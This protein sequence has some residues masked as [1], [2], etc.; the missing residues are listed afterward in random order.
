MPMIKAYQSNF[1][2][3]II[4]SRTKNSGLLRQRHIQGIQPIIRK[5]VDEK[6]GELCIFE[7]YWLQS[8][9]SNTLLDD[10]VK[11]LNGK[12]LKREQFDKLNQQER[13]YIR[14]LIALN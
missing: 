2:S 9:I 10:I 1:P 7:I 6:S 11:S 4:V 13:N 8:D 14:L 3:S 5:L 12:I